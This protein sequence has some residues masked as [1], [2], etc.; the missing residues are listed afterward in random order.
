MAKV[1]KTIRV[2]NG[3]VTVRDEA[4]MLLSVEVD[5]A[6]NGRLVS[7]KGEFSPIEGTDF[8]DSQGN[9]R[10]RASFKGDISLVPMLSIPGISRNPNNR[11]V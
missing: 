9:L 6:A 5:P 2:R 1:E 11:G 3:K 7:F 8:E 4:G 10:A